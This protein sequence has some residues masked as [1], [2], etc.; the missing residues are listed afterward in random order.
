MLAALLLDERLDAR[1]LVVN[2][3]VGQHIVR[4]GRGTVTNLHLDA[5]RM[6]LAS[7][8]DRYVITAVN[9]REDF[10]RFVEIAR[11]GAAA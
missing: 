7:A 2:G 6:D 1:V 11:E 5:S 4:V 3:R 8:P 9:N 10:R